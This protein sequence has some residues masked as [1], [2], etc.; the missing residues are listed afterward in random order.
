RRGG[1]RAFP[2]KPR[3][4][5]QD[6][7]RKMRRLAR[8]QAVLA[9]IQSS[10]ALIVDGLKFDEPRTGRF[11]ALLGALQA[12]RGCVFA[13]NGV[14]PALL[15]SSR[16]IPRADIVNVADLNARNILTRRRLVFT[17]DAF[18]TFRQMVA[19]SVKAGD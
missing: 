8:N 7:P 10:D 4:F 1:G 17:K 6:M 14:D 15:K 2:R 12:D 3:D 13:I 9:K 18:E 5:R 19:T 11:V 16:N